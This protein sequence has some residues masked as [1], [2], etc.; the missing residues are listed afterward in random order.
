MTVDISALPIVDAD[1]HLIEAADIWTTRAPAAILDRVP[2]V[3]D[4][5]DKPTWVMDGTVLGPAFLGGVIR[6]DGAKIETD[7]A[8]TEWG[9][10]DV[11]PGAYSLKARLAVMDAAGV[12]TQIAFPNNLGLG[13]QGVAKASG[14]VSLL[15]TCIE[16]YNDYGAEVQEESGNRVLPMAV[17]P[18]WS[19]DACVREARR[20]Y[21]MGMRGVNM[22]ADPSDQGAPDL[23]DP[24][25]EPLWDVCEELALPVHFHIGNSDTSMSFYNTYSWGSQTNAIKWAIGGM[26]LF[27]GNARS[28]V[29]IIA[30][31]MLERH[32]ELK[33]VSVESGVGWFPF[34]MEAL[35]YEMAENAPRELAQL[36]LTP[37]EYFQRQIYA[38][39]WFEK[40]DI[41][42][43]VERLGSDHI[44][45]ETDFPHPT[46][47][48]PEPLKIAAENLELL[49]PEAR[50]NIL[51][52][53]ARKLYR[54]P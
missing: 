11:H 40:A 7:V 52:N 5:D 35:H 16:I 28:I 17:M 32:P 45:F 23:A 9:F 38:T 1:T 6:S 8:Y 20:A 4:L 27:L 42:Q 46:C 43:V 19:V 14:D 53:N 29:N 3:V 48:Y 18:A 44:M 10:E 49:T 22:T 50:N 15:N 31:G 30:C 2:H 36:S 24:V 26:M 47:L 34:V 39:T 13:G 33:I 51:S 54:L 12:T 37:L 21:E 41:A 25:W